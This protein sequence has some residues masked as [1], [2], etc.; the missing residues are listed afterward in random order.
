MS[1]PALWV[2]NDA[3]PTTL[4]LAPAYDMVPTGSG[5][6]AHEFLIAEDS[7]EPTLANA[8][9]VCAQFDLSPQRAALQVA[10]IIGIVNSWQP[11]FRACGVSERDIAELALVIDRD[12]LL[13]ERVNFDAG[14]YTGTPTTKRSRRGRKPF[15]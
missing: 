11:H 6:T 8:M 1:I 3:A 5:A 4:E 9:G 14:H 2:R 12:D 10:E 13:N 15:A 7:P